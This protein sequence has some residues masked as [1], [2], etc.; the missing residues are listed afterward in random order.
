MQIIVTQFN[1]ENL[2]NRHTRLDRSADDTAIQVGLTGIANIDYQGH[3]LCEALTQAQ[4]NN[5]AQAIL[6]CK[7]DIL[8]V[9]EVEDL[10][11]L[12][13]FNDQYLGGYFGAMMC[14]PGNDPRGINVGLCV[15]QDSGITITGV[16]SHMDE[17]DNPD[18]PGMRIQ[19][20]YSESTGTLTV[21]HNLFSRDC[22]EVDVD[23]GGVPLTFLV[24]HFKSQSGKK[25]E[26]DALRVKQAARVAE[27]VK[28]LTARGAHCVVIG[29]LNIGIDDPSLRSIKGLITDGNLV[30]PFAGTTDR[31]THFFTPT[32]ETSRLDYILP[33]ASL[34]YTVK[35]PS[36]FR[37]GITLRCTTAGDRYAT[38]GQ[39]GTEASDHCPVSVALDLDQLP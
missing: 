20:Y 8:A 3:P 19:R 18:R 33:S 4:R 14:I 11:T 9:E 27:L 2:F 24:N 28:G 17:V 26:S 39:V 16:R 32:K 38:I 15:R 12:R 36:I 37:K 6:D 21:E 10:W 22:L 5:T 35:A 25:S 1:L 30:D 7:P 34:K 13:L 29:D 31:W 23:A